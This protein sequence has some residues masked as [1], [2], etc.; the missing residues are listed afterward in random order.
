MNCLSPPHSARRGGAA[1]TGSTQASPGM[2]SWEVREEQDPTGCSLW[3][4]HPGTEG[5]PQETGPP[6]SGWGWV[7]AYL[8]RVGVASSRVEALWAPLTSWPWEGM[9]RDR[10]TLV[11]L[12]L[13]ALE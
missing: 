1:G 6:E 4:L 3:P 7:G 11:L 5:C 9:T 2:W 13:W 10:V 8:V 12:V